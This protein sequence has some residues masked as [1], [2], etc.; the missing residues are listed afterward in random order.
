[1]TYTRKKFKKLQNLNVNLF[2]HRER[3]AEEVKTSEN[4]NL[5]YQKRVFRFS[6]LKTFPDFSFLFSWFSVFW[7]CVLL[8]FF[9]NPW[10]S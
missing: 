4:I 5:R 2:E 3:E 10:R 1:M 9:R 8:V 6:F 7:I